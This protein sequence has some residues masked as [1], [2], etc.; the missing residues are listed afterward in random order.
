VLVNENG[1]ETLT[2]AIPLGI[3]QIDGRT[4]N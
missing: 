3:Q 1:I 4:S 2:G